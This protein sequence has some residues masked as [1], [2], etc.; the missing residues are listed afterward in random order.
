MMHVLQGVFDLTAANSTIVGTTA[1]NESGTAVE[2]VASRWNLLVGGV[3]VWKIYDLVLLGLVSLHGFNGLR[4]VLTDYTSFS[5]LLK[6]A[7]IY[8]SVIGAATLLALGAGALIYSI[9]DSAIAMAQ[10]AQCKLGKVEDPALCG[11]TSNQIDEIV[12]SVDQGS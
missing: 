2:F 1:L 12:R 6:R 7:A 11:E 9:N 3:A 10:E 8:V 5:P 4:Y